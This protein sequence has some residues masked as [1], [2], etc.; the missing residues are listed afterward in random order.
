M[1]TI[2][3]SDPCPCGSGDNYL[4]CHGKLDPRIWDEY[5][6]GRFAVSF[7][8]PQW[9]HVVAG[10]PQCTFDGQAMPRGILA[11][12]LPEDSGWPAI[13][14][15]V[16]ATKQA[17]KGLVVDGDGLTKT[18]W[19]ETDVVDLGERKDEVLRLVRSLLKDL[20]EPF[21]K[22]KINSVVA[23]NI[24]RYGIG[25]Y[26]R[27]HADSDEFNTK[28]N[29]WEKTQ[30]VDLSFLLYLDDDYEGGEINF[31]NF[32]FQL[33]PRAGMLLMF[34]SDCR[35]LHGVLPVTAGVRHSI[36]SWC[37]IHPRS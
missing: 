34:P 11:T 12:T 4:H 30:D 1:S 32:G 26:Y 18:V 14:D 13:A 27:P 37:N 9:A 19:R 20:A 22:C 16:A 7:S 36:V 2:D 31:P 21:Y 33:R 8:D 35:Y 5:A 25:G 3:L 24:L 23:P 29:K 15:Y 6:L 17:R 10:E 28:T